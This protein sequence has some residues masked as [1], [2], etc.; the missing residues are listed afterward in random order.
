[1][2]FPAAVEGERGSWRTSAGS[3]CSLDVAYRYI[4]YMLPYIATL[5]Y[6]QE[7]SAERR[8]ALRLETEVELRRQ[9]MDLEREMDAGKLKV[10]LHLPVAS[11]PPT[12]SS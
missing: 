1:M 3:Q 12:T 6:L 4:R 11:P 2:C 7:E 5:L 10:G 8:E 9:R